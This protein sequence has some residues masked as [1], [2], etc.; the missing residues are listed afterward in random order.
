MKL[1]QKQS[2]LVAKYKSEISQEMM[3]NINVAKQE[4]YH[5]QSKYTNLVN[6][7]SDVNEN[8]QEIL[9]EYHNLLIKQNQLEKNKLFDNDSWKHRQQIKNKLNNYFQERRNKKHNLET[10][11]NCICRIYQKLIDI[12]NI[13]MDM[14]QKLY[15][16][17]QYNKQNID[18]NPTIYQYLNLPVN[19]IVSQ[20]SYYQF[21]RQMKTIYET[22]NKK[23]DY[24]DLH[25]QLKYYLEKLDDENLK[26]T[27]I[28]EPILH[29][30]GKKDNNQKLI[31]VTQDIK[32]IEDKKDLYLSLKQKY[33]Y[34]ITKMQEILTKIKQIIKEQENII[35]RK[36]DKKVKNYSL[37]INGLTR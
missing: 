12:E 10:T 28:K 34:K 19:Q 6:I 7:L 36:I 21:R 31:Q 33:N 35:K 23:Y 16:Q 27:Y 2:Y 5:I 24:H 3:K 14:F 22:I 11:I 25:Q 26:L 37:K 20:D 8:L 15:S 17:F 1:N 29:P 4:W 32:L 30:P 18:I 9:L 13:K